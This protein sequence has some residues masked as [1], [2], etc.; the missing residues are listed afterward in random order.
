MVPKRSSSWV[1]NYFFFPVDA[2]TS[3]PSKDFVT[4]A[5]CEKKMSYHGGTSPMRTHIRL[6]HKAEFAEHN[7][8]EVV[9]VS[10]DML[11][12]NAAD[13]KVKH[14]EQQSEVE[15]MNLSSLVGL[16]VIQGILYWLALLRVGGH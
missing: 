10:Q 15:E 1:W 7:Q 3:L 12:I 5:L 13:P 11:N 6:L 9:E 8:W 16:S 2:E 4:C 14:E